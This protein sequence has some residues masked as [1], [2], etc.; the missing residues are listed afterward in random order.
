MHATDARTG[1]FN[2]MAG[3]KDPPDRR[4]AAGGGHVPVMLDEVLDA[5]SVRNDGDYLD[6]TFGGGGYS[7][8]ILAA[9]P[10]RLF[11]LDRDP[12]AVE[13]G[14][15]L[16]EAEEKFTMLQGRFGSM[17]RHLAEIDVEQLDGIVLDIGVS[18]QQIDTPERGFSFAADG[19]LDMRMEQ[20][21][22]SAADVVNHADEQTLATIIYRYGEERASRRIARAIVDRRGQ[23]PIT[24]TGELAD[25]VAGVLGRRGK[26]DPATRT[27]QALRIHVN[28]EL[29]ELERA[30][31]AAEHL[32]RPGGRLV[33]VA[34]HSLEDR[35]V[36][37][38]LTARSGQTAR[39]SRHLPERP[40]DRAPR[41]RPLSK[42]PV[43][44]SDAEI[45][46]NPRAR[47]ARLRAAERLLADE[48]PRRC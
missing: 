7:R 33:V 35:I 5:L 2:P 38:F 46:A 29:G 40:A 37:Q 32:L 11:A 13:R 28:D 34:F 26:I 17:D 42:R 9:G 47:S 44:P 24:R 23:Q 15:T 43:T 6:G 4:H 27:F 41:F 25:I 48:E 45:A 3:I 22:E 21:G 8:A 30:L 31:E 20:N 19:P 12:L 18:S 39:P 14:E 10:G 1:H 16:A 36:K